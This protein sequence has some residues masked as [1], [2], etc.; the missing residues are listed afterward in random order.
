MNACKVDTFDTL[1]WKGCKIL[2]TMTV[3]GP[4]VNPFKNSR[5]RKK[6]KSFIV[7]CQKLK[8]EN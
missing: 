7:V 8:Y 4:K 1:F 6:Q 2:V 5:D 3:S